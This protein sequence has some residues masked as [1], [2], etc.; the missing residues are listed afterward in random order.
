MKV[1]FDTNILVS[2]LVTPGGRGEAA[3]QRVISGGDRLVISRP[4]ILE[5]LGVLSRKFSRNREQVARVAVFLDDIGDIVEPT[6]TLHVLQD[7]PDNRVLECAIA[8]GATTVVTGDRAMLALECYRDV[9][10]VSLAR[11]LGLVGRP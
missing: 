7:E 3:L 2:T 8:G 5:L 6:E 10:I 4:V 1:V 9:A 11:Y